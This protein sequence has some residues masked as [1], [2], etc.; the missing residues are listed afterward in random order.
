MIYAAPANRHTQQ[1]TPAMYTRWIACIPYA[2]VLESTACRQHTS[3][4]LRTDARR[5]QQQANQLR[6]AL[7]CNCTHVVRGGTQPHTLQRT[8]SVAVESGGDKPHHPK[9]SSSGRKKEQGTKLAADSLPDKQGR[10][11]AKRKVQHADTCQP[12]R[13]DTI[14]HPPAPQKVTV[15]SAYWPHNQCQPPHSI[16][17]KTHLKTPNIR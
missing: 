15:Q 9:P 17:V 6:L 7:H 13:D 4:D 12:A 5:K 16:Q 8:E 2:A 11:E 10:G 1:C 3:V 14:T